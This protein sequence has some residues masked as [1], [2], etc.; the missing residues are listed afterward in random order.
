MIKVHGGTRSDADKMLCRSCHN[1]TVAEGPD[2]TL[3]R[4][5]DMGQTIRFK[6]TECTSYS[7]KGRPHLADL[8]RSAWILSTDKKN[9]QIGFLPYKKWKEENPRDSEAYY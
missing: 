9:R 1:G 3:I 4:C 7:D 8:Y 5:S 2:G 6:V